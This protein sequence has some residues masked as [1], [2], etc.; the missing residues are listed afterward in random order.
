MDE[1]ETYYWV[2]LYP[3]KDLG[4]PFLFEVIHKD[5][6][7]EYYLSSTNF[8]GYDVYKINNDDKLIEKLEVSQEEILQIIKINYSDYWNRNINVEPSTRKNQSENSYQAHKLFVLA[9]YE[10]ILKI[11]LDTLTK[12]QYY[13]SDSSD[14]LSIIKTADI[15]TENH[16]IDEERFSIISYMYRTEYNE[17]YPG[18]LIN[19]QNTPRIISKLIDLDEPIFDWLFDKLEGIPCIIDVDF[20]RNSAFS[21]GN[22]T[23]E[24]YITPFYFELCKHNIKSVLFSVD[25]E[26]YYIKTNKFISDEERLQKLGIYSGKPMDPNNN[27]KLIRNAKKVLG[28]FWHKLTPT[29]QT[30]FPVGLEYYETYRLYN[31]NILD[32]SPASIQFSKLVETEIEQKL[33][34]PFRDFFNKSEFK[35]QDLTSDLKD[36]DIC[37]MTGFL[38]N[39]ES[40]APELGTFAYFLSV[41]LNSKSRAKTSPTIKS[42]KEYIKSFDDSNFL[43]SKLLFDILTTISSEYRNG[44]A[45]TKA[46]DY[47]KIS[48]FY[49][50]LIGDKN[51][52][53]IFTLLNSLNKKAL[54]S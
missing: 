21:F 4:Y 15:L 37:R 44:A 45:H 2:E 32:C 35:T 41:A 23:L 7:A 38:N 43:L 54:T 46:L 6:K 13:I 18:C 10:T 31:G 11:L 19:V 14:N 24:R 1:S 9:D 36:K 12:L 29:S 42:Y 22:S 34:L 47:I 52:G 27:E 50:M 20:N 53:F 5:Y 16:Q 40:K 51:D 28:E 33:L 39:P 8:Y 17:G 26:A 25:N 3:F 30:I 48:K 49:K